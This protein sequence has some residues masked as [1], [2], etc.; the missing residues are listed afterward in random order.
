[1]AA[2]TFWP[3]TRATP[4]APGLLEVPSRPNKAIRLTAESRADAL[5]RADVW[6]E[7]RDRSSAALARTPD[8]TG[9]FAA[10]PVECR[11]EPEAAHGTTSK[12]N[13]TLAD[14]EVIKVKY[15]GTE[16]IQAEVAASRLLERLGFGADDMFIVSRV[17][18]YGCPRLPFEL[19]WATERFG[20]REALMRRFSSGRYVD[21]TWA[22]VE[23]RFPA[24]SIESEDV[25]G[26]AWYELEA[27]APSSEASHTE[28]DALR[29]AAVLLAHWDNKSAN[30][31][32]VCLDRDRPQQ[33]CA[34][35][36]AMIH[37]LGATFGPNKVDLA[38]WAA[39]PIW[40]DAARC[41]VSM[42]QF[43]YDGGTFRDWQISEA[44]RQLLLQE[45]ATISGADAR[46]WFESARFENVHDWSATFEAK[47]RKIADA[48]PCP[49]PP[50]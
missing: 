5:H 50:A 18:C 14:G 31:R 24:P 30:Q 13:C 23:R 2:L 41:T 11:Y 16:E 44:G 1:V 29:L 46:A 38:H 4:T 20:L 6:H 39:A 3:G 34:A 28:R 35:P 19:S 42:R 8:P 48:G 21:F 37:D 15:G 9:A 43:P 45:L 17:R 33:R 10:S 27:I 47:V 25:E 32:L 7:P 26:W 36:F 12:F 22:A 40:K 49:P